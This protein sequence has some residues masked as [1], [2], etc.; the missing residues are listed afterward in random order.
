MPRVRTFTAAAR[1]AMAE[2][3]ADSHFERTTTMVRRAL[4]GLVLGL[5]TVCAGLPTP[6]L[7]GQAT[8]KPTAIA[9]PNKVIEAIGTVV[10]LDGSASTNPSGT[11]LLYHWAFLAVP[12]GSS[13][14]LTG[15]DTVTPTFVP[16]RPGRYRVQLTVD[17]GR[18]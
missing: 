17:N 18:R 5:L 13:A 4:I 9:G 3:C 11:P 8:G 2:L 10:Q 14:A 16:D 1:A 7:H 15:A 12:A 6:V